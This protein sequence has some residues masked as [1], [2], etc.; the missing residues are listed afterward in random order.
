MTDYLQ[1]LVDD[2]TLAAIA[3]GLA[4]LAGFFLRW[5]YETIRNM[6]RDYRYERQEAQAEMDSTR[7]LD[8]LYPERVQE[9][10][11]EEYFRVTTDGKGYRLN[12][13]WRELVEASKPRSPEIVAEQTYS[14]VRQRRPEPI[15]A[16][17]YPQWSIEER[18]VAGRH[19]ADGSAL[20]AVNT[21][22][23]EWKLVSV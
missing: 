8:G 11:N 18:T 4:V 12:D 6:I 16:Q 21:P 20:R 3:L 5:V 2:R 1:S 22:T 15:K 7:I 17:A 9:I 10:D 14:F 19:R 23:Q 13:K